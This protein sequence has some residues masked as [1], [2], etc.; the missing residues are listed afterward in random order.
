MVA[1]QA[2]WVEIC[3]I[4]LL[5]SYIFC[6][7]SEL[8]NS[9]SSISFK[10]ELLIVFPLRKLSFDTFF[11]IF[12]L[13]TV[14]SDVAFASLLKA[15]TFCVHFRSFSANDTPCGL[16]EIT[17]TFFDFPYWKLFSRLNVVVVVVWLY[18]KLF[19]S[20]RDENLTTDSEGWRD[21]SIINWGRSPLLQ[22]KF[23]TSVLRESLIW[24]ISREFSGIMKL[25]R[26]NVVIW[27]P[28]SRAPNFKVKALKL[29]LICDF[30]T[31]GVRLKQWTTSVNW[32]RYEEKKAEKNH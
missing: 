27:C 26:L 3:L 24:I 28:G 22:A 17:R 1:H 23:P 32:N 20:C 11:D 16:V 18:D 9:S 14:F 7:S 21:R 25:L 2:V 5:I 6:A 8:V 29:L 31:E 13:F 15:K 4:S 10:L 19:D 30:F 12:G